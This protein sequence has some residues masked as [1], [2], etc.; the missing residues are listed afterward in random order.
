MGALTSGLRAGG[1][2]PRVRVVLAVSSAAAVAVTHATWLLAGPLGA[3]RTIAMPFWL[4]AALGLALLGREYGAARADVA[5]LLHLRGV[6]PLTRLAWLSAGPL[7]ACLLGAIAGVGLAWLV[8]PTVATLLQVTA[9]G[10]APWLADGGTA[11]AS[12]AVAAM[13]AVLGS[14]R[15]DRNEVTGRAA[16]R[17]TS[18]VT[19][20]A[21]LALWP[22]ALLVLW[23]AW[24]ATD[25]TPAWEAWTGP[26]IIA[27]AAAGLLNRL[28]G[29]AGTLLRRVVR[30]DD[31]EAWLTSRRLG[32]G[33]HL[34]GPTRLIVATAVFAGF[35]AV[36]FAGTE[37]HLDTSSRVE[38]GAASRYEFD[39]GVLA[40][41]T[42]AEKI[43]PGGDYVAAGAVLPPT[44]APDDPGGTVYLDGIRAQA[45]MSPELTGTDALASLRA[46]T[47]VA[48]QSQLT[49]ADRIT[50]RANVVR[51]ATLQVTLD[52][53]GDDD[54]LR[55][56]KVRVRGGEGRPTTTDARLAN[57]SAG[58]QLVSVTLQA[59]GPGR[60]PI[61]LRGTLDQLDVG[62][63]RLVRSDWVGRGLETLPDGMSSTDNGRWTITTDRRLVLTPPGSADPVPIISAT[64][65]YTPTVTTVGAGERPVAS[66][67]PVPAVPILGR[68]GLLLDLR[69]ALDDGGAVPDVQVF[70]LA[71]ADTPDAVRRQLEALDGVGA[72]PLT[73]ESARERLGDRAPRLLLGFAGLAALLAAAVSLALLPGLRDSRATEV[74][75]LR[76]AG[77]PGRI[78]HRSERRATRWRAVA[79]T[80]TTL[81]G[82]WLAV[83]LLIDP[84]PLARTATWAAAPAPGGPWPWLVVTAAAA[85]L[86]WW[87][88]ARRG[89]GERRGRQRGAWRGGPLGTVQRGIRHRALLSVGAVTLLGL[90]VG[91]AVLGPTFADAVVR[92]YLVTRLADTPTADSSLVWTFTPDGSTSPSDQMRTLGPELAAL[93]HGPWA[94]P[95]LTLKQTVPG[96][97]LPDA[98][99]ERQGK[100]ALRLLARTDGC[101][102]LE[103]SG[104][105]P[106]A[107]GEVLMLDS[108]LERLGVAVGDRVPTKD[109]DLAL[110]IVGSY[111]PPTTQPGSFWLPGSDFLNLGAYVDRQGVQHPMQTGALVTAPQTFDDVPEPAGGDRRIE[112]VTRLAVGEDL[113]V[114]AVRDA[115][116]EADAFEHAAPAVTGGTIVVEPTSQSLTAIADDLMQQ[117]RAARTSIA[118]AV[119]SLILVALAL[120]LRLLSAGNQLR[121]PE[122]ALASL[123]GASKRTLWLLAMAE[124]LLLIAVAAPLGAGFGYGLSVALA[125]AWL[126]PGLS[127]PVPAVTGWY[128]AGV[129]IGAVAVAAIAVRQMLRVPL[130]GQL[131][132]VFRPA[133]RG[134]IVAAVFVAALVALLGARVLA[135]DG[136]PQ[137]TDLLIPT[138]IGVVAGLLATWLVVSLARLLVRSRAADRSLTAFVL[139][140]SVARR[141][142]NSLLVLPLVAALAIGGLAVG[143]HGAAAQWR[144]SVATTRAPADQVWSSP[145]GPEE[146]LALTDRIDPD[147]EWAMASSRI[148]RPPGPGNPV[149]FQATLIDT[150]RLPTVGRWWHQWTPGHDAT[151]IRDRLGGF[152]PPALRGRTVGATI[153]N[154]TGSDLQVVVRFL[155][156]GG[157][158][159]S[160]ELGPFRD[161]RTDT[162]DVALPHCAD[163]CELTN[164]EIGGPA[165]FA[166]PMSGEITL[167]PR[168]DER[169]WSAPA[170]ARI[171]TP[172]Q[173]GAD[174]PVT[175]VEAD[176]D[177]LVIG[178]D[179][180]GGNGLAILRFTP[181]AE[182][183]PV[184]VGAGADDQL[185]S[186]GGVPNVPW[187]IRPIPVEP[188][189][190]SASVPF[191]GPQ[192]L[193]IDL[194]QFLSEAQLA[195]GEGQT[196]ILVRDGAPETVTAA[197]RDAGATEVT[198]FE[199]ELRLQE[200]SAF[201]LALRMYVVVAALVLLMALA[202]MLITTAVQLPARRR[203]AAAL[204]VVG[205]PRSVISRAVIGEQALMLGVAVLA[206][207]L[208]G[209][210]AARLLVGTLTLGTVD[211][212]DVPAVLAELDRLD[213]TLLGLGSFAVLLLIAVVGTLRTVRSARGSTLREA[214]G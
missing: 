79:V 76:L 75:G 52:Y 29:P 81:A 157:G 4:L 69:A 88:V 25:D 1:V 196:R 169:T 5:A 27:L 158:R 39:G 134:P 38:V 12:L 130:A 92:S 164:L 188:T 135:G 37:E 132:P 72:G 198:T 148:T 44:T 21:G 176:G 59:R 189:Y 112:V 211:A 150:T 170:A 20:L 163:G 3:S 151:D 207:V 178:I 11:L 202:A 146:S 70:L 62:D 77:V 103:L 106:D 107:A 120:L 47:E 18:T 180:D 205:V 171:A 56:A 181:D 136:R 34:A 191:G 110:T 193:M 155:T 108:D 190:E 99:G 36:T 83:R 9:T 32:R 65:R 144:E 213:L 33:G 138:A 140:R 10:P 24:T 101:A 40:A 97:G 139:G 172:G 105:C 149:A 127:V 133:A 147:G 50:V 41:L 16:G 95:E 179:T 118:P 192:D 49:T 67:T 89:G 28:A 82:L 94:D 74:A 209:A 208:S 145:V 166:L 114:G 195:P 14:R 61:G 200:A 85:G 73:P 187:G 80:L 126:A 111:V 15:R 201:A 123:R 168:L 53:V 58:C 121:I 152:R 55:T 23:H 122:L 48:D 8:T 159:E 167:T 153:D 210:A 93:T 6:R 206:G 154:Q 115:A 46:L 109:P 116:T 143:I 22:L 173:A 87:S 141:R 68:D 7:P 124:P 86:L 204:R 26:V 104:A 137:P 63:L 100:T 162:R 129:L 161:G 91:S 186:L 113:R 165:G 98:D 102:H 78:R 203:D 64:D 183:M 66:V 160:V 35:A 212:A 156:R 43:D 142:E 174:T 71:A 185:Q 57:C 42:A 177:R 54:A 214:A 96:L 31:L 131:S 182:L 175:D 194:R 45:V 51:T 199:A 2:R 17:R 117:E 125:R 197:L 90:A 184:L 84:L 128:A 119:L 13:A 19:T 60:G 30:A